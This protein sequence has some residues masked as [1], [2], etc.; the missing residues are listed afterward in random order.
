MA[1]RSPDDHL[2]PPV[3]YLLTSVFI[4]GDLPAIRQRLVV[5]AREC[6][7]PGDRAGDWVIAV[8]ELMANAIRHGDGR[9]R[10]H[11]W[12]DGD[13]CC[14]VRDWGPGFDARPYVRRRDRPP[15]SA[16]GGMGL[17]IAQQMSQAM[18]IDSGPSGTVVV[19]RTSLVG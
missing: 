16:N 6:G 3:P 4:E 14:E 10:L 7:L 11:V 15:P 18:H 9:G 17:W 2:L 13:L 1:G 8:N 12:R 5:I 19:L